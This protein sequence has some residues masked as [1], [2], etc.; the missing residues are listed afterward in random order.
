MLYT[1]TKSMLENMREKN[2]SLRAVLGR[3]R[4]NILSLDLVIVSIKVVGTMMD[5][6]MKFIKIGTK[7]KRRN[8][9]HSRGKIGI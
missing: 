3:K 6:F 8:E 4:W 2:R 9:C 5:K 1:Q 7:K